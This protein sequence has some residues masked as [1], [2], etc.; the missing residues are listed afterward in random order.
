[1][2]CQ[3]SA[4]GELELKVD[5]HKTSYEI[6]TFVIKSVVRYQRRA[7][8]IL[9]HFLQLRQTFHNFDLKKFREFPARPSLTKGAGRKPL[10]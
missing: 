1:M 7:G 5:I 4:N 3:C 10:R 2:S 9:G 8:N 6:L